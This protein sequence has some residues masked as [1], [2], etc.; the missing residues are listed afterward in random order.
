[1]PPIDI[2]GKHRDHIT[3]VKCLGSKNNQVNWDCVC[4]CGNHFVLTTAEF[5]YG[6]RKSCGHCNLKY[7][8]MRNRLTRWHGPDELRISQIFKGMLKRCYNQNCKSYRLYGARGI[9][10]CDEW[11]NDRRKFVEWSLQN[12]YGPGKS[13]DRIDVNGPYAPWNCRWSSDL[14]QAN[15]KQDSRFVTASDGTR[16][17]IAEWARAIGVLPIILYKL[18]IESDADV[19]WYIN[20]KWEQIEQS[21]KSLLIDKAKSDY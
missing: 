1:M 2:T 13:I 3:V 20:Y 17:T 19:E 12:G 4:D 21:D 8:T 6:S 15:N 5:N 16:L 10:V 9:Y 7:E 18:A 11:R 14:C